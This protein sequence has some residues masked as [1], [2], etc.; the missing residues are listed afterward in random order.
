MLG[1]WQ[2]PQIQVSSIELNYRQSFYI[3]RPERTG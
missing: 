3:A 2:L 1:V